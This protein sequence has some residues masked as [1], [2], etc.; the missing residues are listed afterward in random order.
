MSELFSAAVWDA[1]AVLTAETAIWPVVYAFVMLEMI[2]LKLPLSFSCA[3]ALLKLLTSGQYAGWL[4]LAA[5]V[6]LLLAAVVLLLLAAVVLLLLAAVVLL[7]LPHPA[8][9]AAA[10]RASTSIAARRGG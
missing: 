10:T 5:V 1:N 4:P 8:N 7:L 3:A 9:N 6:L 2:A